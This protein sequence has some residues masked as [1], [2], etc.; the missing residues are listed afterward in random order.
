MFSDRNKVS[1]LAACSSLW[2]PSPPSNGNMVPSFQCQ[3]VLLL[4]VCLL[5]LPPCR[6]QFGA[7][8]QL[9]INP[10]SM[11]IPVLSVQE[12]VGCNYCTD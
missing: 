10:D 7:M 4:L 2:L 8:I 5:R 12:K 1:S 11:N 3:I 9:E 6:G